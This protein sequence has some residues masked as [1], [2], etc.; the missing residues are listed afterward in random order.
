MQRAAIL[1]LAILLSVG[2]ATAYLRTRPHPVDIKDVSPAASRRDRKLTVHVAGA[3]ACPGV[4]R[5]DEGSRVAD[6]IEKAGGTSPDAMLDDLNLASRLRDGQKVMVPRPAPVPQAGTLDPVGAGPGLINVN[7]AD[8]AELDKLPGVGP[9]LAGRIIDHRKKNGPFSSMK[10]LDGV[11][12]I[13]PSK[14]EALE[15]LVTF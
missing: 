2:S 8:I 1:A 6:A 7:T 5:I 14:L 13:G 10:D 9:A 3:V 15:D 4:Y 12:G 11:E